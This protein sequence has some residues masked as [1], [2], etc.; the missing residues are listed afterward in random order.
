MFFIVLDVVF[1]TMLIPDEASS[2]AQIM[3]GIRYIDLAMDK[4]L[5]CGM[6]LTTE[7]ISIKRE[8]Y[9]IKPY[10]M[11]SITLMSGNTLFK[12]ERSLKHY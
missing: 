2:A 6:S 4:D 11:N 9:V 12:V 8:L 1:V 7:I 3:S 10:T 5:V